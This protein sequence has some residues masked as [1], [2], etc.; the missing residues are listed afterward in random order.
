VA[1][2]AINS[3]F[4]HPMMR[5]WFAHPWFLTA[6]AVLPVLA[7]LT[8]WEAR[9][10]RRALLVLGDIFA[11]DGI[12]RRRARGLGVTMG[13]VLLCVAAAG[14]QWGRDWDQPAAPGRDL[15]VVLDCSRSMLA[16]Q[17]SR[18]ERARAALL[19]LCDAIGRRGGHRLGLV[20]VAAR[21]RLVC[22]L[23]HDCDHV[24]DL[25]VRLD[26]LLAAGELQ[27]GPGDV[28]GTRLGAGLR[29]A[30][31]AHDLRFRGSQ[32]IVLL[33]DGDDPAR[34]GEWRPGAEAARAAGMPVYAVGLGDP[35]ADSIIRE[36]GEVL[37]HEGRQVHTRL[38]EAPLKEIA[39]ITGGRYV[40][41]RTQELP[42]GELYLDELA[43]GPLREASDDT[44]PAYRP[45]YT[46]FL[47]PALSLLALALALPDRG[48][49]RLRPT[50]GDES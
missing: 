7:G 47:M 37:R 45:R 39:R 18:L 30:V 40:A 24:C 20:L 50:E 28:S 22:P 32:D 16:E 17:P 19:G 21:A 26:D 14:P 35:D 1:A 36:D 9:R 23:T 31:A 3:D 29:E 15:V 27:P 2:T 43:A 42:L 33:S 49:R 38:E 46:L 12:G 10:R 48:P 44:L 25:V 5:H 6:L 8:L 13:L 4:T 41:A 34:D 11:R